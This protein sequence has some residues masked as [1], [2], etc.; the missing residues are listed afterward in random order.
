MCSMK[1]ELHEYKTSHISKVIAVVAPVKVGPTPDDNILVRIAEMNDKGMESLSVNMSN[2]G[3]F[4]FK[5]GF[6][7]I[8]PSE[9]YWFRS[10]KS[11]S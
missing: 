2:T 9:L 11:I 7:N 10:R 5:I 6:N 1:H 4:G 3:S 8:F